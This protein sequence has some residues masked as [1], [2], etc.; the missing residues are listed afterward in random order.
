MIATEPLG[1]SIA[2]QLIANDAAVSDLNFI[3]DYFRLSADRRLLSGGR[4]SYS[5]L[6]FRDIAEGLR[7]RMLRVFPQL[8]NVGVDYAWGVM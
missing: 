7:P 3:L 6:Q 5:K 4:V 2:R 1:E 8:R